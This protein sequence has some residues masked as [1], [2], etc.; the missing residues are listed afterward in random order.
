M[1]L[2]FKFYLL[3]IYSLLYIAF[4]RAREEKRKQN[5]QKRLQ[6]E[7]EKEQKREVEGKKSQVKVNKENPKKTTR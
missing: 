7:K 2:S 6:M 4:I 3:N 5:L 1:I